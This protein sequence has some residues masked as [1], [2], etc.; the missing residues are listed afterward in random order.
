MADSAMSNPNLNFGETCFERS[1]AVQ[2]QD[3]RSYY[4]LGIAYDHKGDKPKAAEAYKKA[5]S[6]RQ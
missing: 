5:E 2:P 6:L 4:Y 3:W 1:V